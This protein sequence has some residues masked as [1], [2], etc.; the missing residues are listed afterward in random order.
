[1]PA[2]DAT[3]RG[4]AFA[5]NNFGTA[6]TLTVKNDATADNTAG[7]TRAGTLPV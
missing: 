6:T 5:G 3:V 4:G 2:A 1:M 7:R